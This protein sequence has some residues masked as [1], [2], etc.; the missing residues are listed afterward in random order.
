[1]SP[2]ELLG[3][4]RNRIIHPLVL[5]RQSQNIDMLIS[6]FFLK[7]TR[8]ALIM[9]A[10]S[11][12]VCAADTDK[13]VNLLSDVR[14]SQLHTYQA[15]DE[16]GM[17]MDCLKVFQT[18]K[19][20]YMG[21]YHGFHNG[22]F[23]VHLARSTDLL[24]WKHVVK[25]DDHASQATI[26][27]ADDDSYLIAYEKALPNSCW[28]RLRSYECLTKLSNG[29]FQDEYDIPRSLAP[30]A[31]GT[32]SFELVARRGN[33]LE[34][35]EIRLRF[36][37]YKDAHVDRLAQGTLRDFKAWDAQPLRQINAE[38]ISRGAH[39]NI[40]DRDRFEWKGE[41]FYLQEVQFKRGDW[42]SWRVFLCD[43]EGMPIKQ[44]PVKTHSGSVAFCNPNITWVTDA[45]GERKLVV[46]LFLPSEGSAHGEAGE[47]I[48][49]IDPG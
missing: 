45:E 2:D 33:T 18:E 28:I 16:K 40:G 34:H 43:A 41:S 35:S 49:V 11:L 1:M 12:S 5:S 23:S 21:L 26:W 20:Q 10:F 27:I 25:L 6:N 37:Y 17:S 39:G 29:A 31:E 46:T 14:A 24:S 8:S 3:E 13:L 4:A 42:S 38:L 7:T 19:G 9:L 48:Y 36:H 15:K 47:L 32:P 22:V 30:T 44:L